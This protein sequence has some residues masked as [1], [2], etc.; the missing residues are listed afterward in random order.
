MKCLILYKDWLLLNRGEIRPEIGDK[1]KVGTCYYVITEVKENG[2]CHVQLDYSVLQFTKEEIKVINIEIS[3]DIYAEIDYNPN[4]AIEFAEWILHKETEKGNFN[5]TSYIDRTNGR[6]S[7]HRRGFDG[8]DDAGNGWLR[9][10]K[11]DPKR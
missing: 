10:H 5:I 8:Y 7:R 11:T 3:D 9:N 6:K 1:I 4:E 2:Y